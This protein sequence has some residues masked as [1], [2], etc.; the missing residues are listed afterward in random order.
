MQSEDIVGG[1]EFGDSDEADRLGGIG[2]GC[3]AE[4]AG[5]AR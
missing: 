5:D 1:F 3:L 2:D 4:S